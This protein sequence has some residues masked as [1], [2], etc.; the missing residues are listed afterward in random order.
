MDYAFCGIFSKMDF[1]FRAVALLL[2]SNSA[3]RG[4]K[5]KV[6]GS[7]LYPIKSNP[8]YKK[9]ILLTFIKNGKN[10]IRFQLL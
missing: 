4:V 1:I 8:C 6:S 9:I 7:K 10:G 3:G 5:F 2:R